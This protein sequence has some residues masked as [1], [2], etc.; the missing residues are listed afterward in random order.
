ML[1]KFYLDRDKNI[2]LTAGVTTSGT[3][4][5]AGAHTTITITDDTPSP[6]FY[7]CTAHSYMGHSINVLGGKQSR[8]NITSATATG[9]L[10]GANSGKSFT[11]LANRTVNDILVFVNGICMVPTTDYTVSGTT[12]TFDT[13]PSTGAEIQFRYLG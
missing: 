7:E 10:A 5:N 6:I 4:G 1:L 12:L 13:A 3:A 8:L 9:N 2:E 11:I